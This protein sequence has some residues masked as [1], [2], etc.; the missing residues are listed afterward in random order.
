ML[1]FYAPVS[2]LV[3]RVALEVEAVNFMNKELEQP[4]VV[5]SLHGM[6][7][8]QGAN[9]A[10]LRYTGMTDVL[11]KTVQADGFKGL[12]RVSSIFMNWGM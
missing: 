10:K 7:Q 11:R 5:S 2:W 6:L 3:K 8:A 12:Y 1:H 9:G 4:Q